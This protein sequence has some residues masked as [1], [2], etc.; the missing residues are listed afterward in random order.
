MVDCGGGVPREKGA[1]TRVFG[2]ANKHVGLLL[3]ASMIVGIAIG[4]LVPG[5]RETIERVTFG[6]KNLLI[7]VALMVMMYPPLASVQ[8]EKLHLVMGDMRLLGL[9]VLLN[10]VIGPLLMFALAFLFFS[11]R[12]EFL[13]GLI[14]IGLVRCI[15]SVIVWNDLAEGDCHYCVGLAGANV[16]FQ[17]LLLPLYVYLFITVLPDYL[18]LGGVM[19]DAPMGLLVR[20]ELVYLIIPLVAGMA[21]RFIG[22]KTMGE[23]RYEREFVPRISP[24][25][26][27]AKVFMV[28]VL[29]SLYGGYVTELTM[30]VLHIALP[31]AIYFVAMFFISY[32]LSAKIGASYEQATTLSFT[33]ASSN[34]ALAM[35]VGISVFGIGSGQAFVAVVGEMVEVPVIAALVH[36]A[37]GLR[38]KLFLRRVECVGRTT[39]R[40]YR[41]CD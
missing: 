23:E 1:A 16:L 37:L 11:G 33:A 15:D 4:H 19:L 36:V 30:D 8:Y 17:I 34:F 12:P 32:L 9:G 29:F 21:S 7:V 13:T 3:V 40:H 35:V 20:S 22:L 27:T 39:S 5:A 28:A 26:L 41:A 2:V 14:L 31:L 6:H 25:S 10:W 24:V 18:G 38:G